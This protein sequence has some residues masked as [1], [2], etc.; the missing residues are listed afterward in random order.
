MFKKIVVA[1]VEMDA[2][3]CWPGAPDH[4][5]YLRGEHMHHFSI[6]IH[7]KVMG[8]DREVEIHDLR[9]DLR[10]AINKMLDE[11]GSFGSLSCE[12]IAEGL[13]KIMKVKYQIQTVKVM[14]EPGCGAEICR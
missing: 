10:F 2:V 7:I 9:D 11:K 14:E 8:S 1:R 13:D 3:H 4:R 5:Y 6:T 12:A